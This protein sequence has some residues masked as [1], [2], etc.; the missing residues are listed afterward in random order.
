MNI[1]KLRLSIITEQSNVQICSILNSCVHE[2]Q[3]R[4][5]KGCNIKILLILFRF[6]ANGRSQNTLKV[7]SPNFQEENAYFASPA[8]AHAC[9]GVARGHSWSHAPTN[10]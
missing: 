2:R 10:Y 1:Q 5:F 9:I 3:Q 7:P 6:N 8:D 4:F